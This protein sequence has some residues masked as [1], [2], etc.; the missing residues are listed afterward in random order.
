MPKNV[1]YLIFHTDIEKKIDQLKLSELHHMTNKTKRIQKKI[2]NNC[3]FMSFI[4]TFNKLIYRRIP[5]D[6]DKAV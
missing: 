5:N 3:N 1:V 4:Y 6:N 2:F